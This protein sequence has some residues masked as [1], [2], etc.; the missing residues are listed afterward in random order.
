MFVLCNSIRRGGCCRLGK[1][2]ASIMFLY[3][4]ALSPSVS[5][6]IVERAVANRCTVDAQ[7]L[8]TLQKQ[9]KIV[10]RIAVFAL[11]VMAM[12][13]LSLLEM[14]GVYQGFT[15]IASKHTYTLGKPLV[16]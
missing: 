16:F 14:K 13:K 6:E 4:P 15:T 10:T 7:H 11:Q 5:L 9:K 1:F 12:Q 8:A 3:V 2:W